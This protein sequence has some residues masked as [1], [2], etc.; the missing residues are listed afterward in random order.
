MAGAS[1]PAISFAGDFFCED[2]RAKNFSSRS[3]QACGVIE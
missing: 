3:F 2:V 1:A